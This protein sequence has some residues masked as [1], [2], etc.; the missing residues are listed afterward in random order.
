VVEE[1]L[2]LKLPPSLPLPLAASLPEAYYTA[3]QVDIGVI[4]SAMVC[5]DISKL[6]GRW[7]LNL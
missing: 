6:A 3:Y 7:R 4:W 2:A 5:V 1:A